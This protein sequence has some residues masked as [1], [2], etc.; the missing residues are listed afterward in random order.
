MGS[1]VQD[2]AILYNFL[3][4]FWLCLFWYLK[5]AR[6][7]LL[8]ATLESKGHN[9]CHAETC[10]ETSSLQRA[11]LTHLRIKACQIS[12]WLHTFSS[13][14]PNLGGP[15]RHWRAATHLYVGQQQE[16]VAETACVPESQKTPPLR[17][18]EAWTLL[19]GISPESWER[20]GY[21]KEQ[22]VRSAKLMKYEWVWGFWR[23]KGF[24]WLQARLPSKAVFDHYFHGRYYQQANN[25][26]PIIKCGNSF[27]F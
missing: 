3:A 26:C 7:S 20:F 27:S 21:I 4:F 18:A 22:S 16:P 2:H 19:Q 11:W 8:G 1:H 25:W 5:G 9:M 12:Q 23:C 24:V 14:S 15:A 6:R 13:I 10:R 17:A